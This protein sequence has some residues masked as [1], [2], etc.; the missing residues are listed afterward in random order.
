MCSHSNDEFVVGVYTQGISGIP[1]PRSN[2]LFSTYPTTECVTSDKNFPSNSHRRWNTKMCAIFILSS[3]NFVSRYFQTLK[4]YNDFF[5]FYNLYCSVC[6]CSHWER[7]WTRLLVRATFSELLRFGE[8]IELGNPSRSST[9]GILLPL[10]EYQGTWIGVWY[11]GEWY[12]LRRVARFSRR[13]N[14]VEKQR[15][16]L[17]RGRCHYDQFLSRVASYRPHGGSSL[18]KRSSIDPRMFRFSY[19]RVCRWSCVWYAKRYVQSRL[20]FSS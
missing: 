18:P 8:W 2:N 9:R 1:S 13:T 3:H 4:F 19:S 7:S 20:T 5:S 17:R 12:Q 16:C 10:P 6:C 15:K 14:D 11:V